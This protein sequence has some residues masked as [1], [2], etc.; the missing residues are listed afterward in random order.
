VNLSDGKFRTGDW[1]VVFILSLVGVVLG[2]RGIYHYGYMGQDFGSHRNILVSFP[3]SFSWKGT[4]PPGLYWLG[5]LIRNHVSLDHYLEVT[6]FV[7]L[8]LNTA[9]LWM[10]Y[11]LLW[12][13]ISSRLLWGAAVALVTLVPFRV[14]H[15]TVLAGDALTLPFFAW[16]ALCTSRLYLD[17]RRG[18]AWAGLA[19][20]L[21][22]GVFCK[23]TF[24]GLLPAVGLLLAVALCR[25]LQGVDRLRWILV[26]ALSLALPT[27]V[28]LYELHQSYAHVGEVTNNQWLF[29]SETSVM[30]W[31]DI[32]TLNPADSGVLSA[33][34]YFGGKLYARR[35]YSY[36][37]LLHL[38]S[39]TDVLNFFQ[40]PSPPVPA[41]WAHRVDEPPVRTRTATSQ[42][43]QVGAVRLG[44]L[45]SLLAVLGTLA[46]L[47][48]G[49][50]SLVAAKPPL[51]DSLVVLTALAT[52]FY[53]QIFFSLHRLRDPYTPGFWLPRLSL[54]AIVT[55]LAL[56]LVGVDWFIQRRRGKGAC[57][58]EWALAGY[59]A[60][61][62][63][64]FIGFLY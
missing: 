64:F 60:L 7:L 59:T 61:T 11:R 8:S 2:L 45:F 29:K 17:P 33:P 53:A 62:C 30:R 13:G 39:F 16:A 1:A 21:S 47:G 46:C 37:A 28:S 34:D 14:I 9:G 48:L 22:L 63:L 32:L 20:A 15:S 52:A 31:R 49:A 27:G 38:A 4:N 3:G 18:W 19:G 10:L 12:E 40:P 43:L 56:G 54:P 26:G 42:I 51:A 23:Y 6:A 41:D 25:R 35:R 44:L 57:I 58:F 24:V 5:S 36:L 50:V 55:F